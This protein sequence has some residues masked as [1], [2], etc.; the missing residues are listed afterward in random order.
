MFGPRRHLNTKGIQHLKQGSELPVAI[1]TT[2]PAAVS[3]ET[4]RV[5]R[6]EKECSGAQRKKR[7]KLTRIFKK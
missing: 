7:N 2:G 6:G 3:R 4:T 5:V 1:L